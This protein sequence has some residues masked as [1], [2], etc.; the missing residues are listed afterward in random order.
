MLASSLPPWLLRKDVTLPIITLALLLLLQL[1]IGFWVSKRI[2]TEDDYLVAG[3]GFGYILGCGSIFATWFGAETVIGSSAT[4]YQEGLTFNS[5][6]PF[7]YGLCLIVFGAVLSRPLWKR[8]LTTLADLYRQRF[9]TTV[10]RIAAIVLIPSSVLWAG[11]QMRALGQVIAGISPIDVELAIGIGA[12]FTIAYTAV[13]GLLADAVTDV[14]QGSILSIA[15]IAMLVVIVT[16][17]GGPAEAL[18]IIESSR[19]LAQAP[20]HPWYVVVESWAIP[21]LGSLAAT[22]VI[23]RSIASRS[24]EVAQRSALGAGALYLLIGSIPVMIALLGS[25]LT[26][27][28]AE[29]EQLLP[30]VAQAWLPAPLYALFVAGLVS[31]LLSTVDST[32]LVASGLLSHN[33]VVPLANV[34]EHRS[35]VR[36]ARLGV[37][38]LGV[39]SYVLALNAEGV[40]AL[41]EQASAFGSAGILVTVMFALFTPWGGPATA[42][43]TLVAGVASYSLAVVLDTP[44][45]FLISLA[46]SLLV[47]LTGCL[48]ETA[49]RRPASAVGT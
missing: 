18:H 47:W 10:E 21:V 9:G 24:P 27:P 39:A 1:G 43:A 35:K 2:T 37:V 49:P 25:T 6:E 17:V 8:Q 14:I 26:G 38:A 33:I 41:V 12:L 45:P 15:L 46:V 36:L 34:T 48:A 30:M 5:A 7:G 11:A 19:S 28:I 4:V 40:F 44:T 22:E 31:A 23:G 42:I 13:G 32:L 29:P 16:Q 20:V 3:R